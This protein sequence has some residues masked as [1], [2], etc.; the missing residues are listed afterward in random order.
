MAFGWALSQNFH[1]YL[2]RRDAREYITSHKFENSD[3]H[4]HL[5][6]HHILKNILLS[7]VL[8][9]PNDIVDVK[10]LL[11]SKKVSVSQGSLPTIGPKTADQVRRFVI[12]MKA[13][14]PIS[15]CIFWRN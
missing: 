5:C 9:Q 7:N 11:S 10:S 12:L 8:A 2:R 4:K 1:L 13:L 15:L 3:L 6:P 14:L